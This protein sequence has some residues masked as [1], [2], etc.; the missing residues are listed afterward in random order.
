[1]NYDI[2]E[3]VEGYSVVNA[4]GDEIGIV[5]DVRGGTA[6]VDPNPGLTDTIRSKLGWNDPDA[7]DFPLRGD[8]IDAIG[9]DR[10]HLKR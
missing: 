7:E 9:D 2:D 3:S 5:S 8:Q 6:Y 1:M 4:S 10:I